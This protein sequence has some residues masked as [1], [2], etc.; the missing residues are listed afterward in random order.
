MVGTIPFAFTRGCIDANGSYVK[1][2]TSIYTEDMFECQGLTIEPD[3]KAS[4]TYQVFYYAADEMFIGATEEMNANDPAYVKGDTFPLAKYCRVLIT[5]DNG[6]D[7][8]FSVKFY[9][10][11]SYAN[12]YTITVNK[13]QVLDI[14]KVFANEA[15]VASLLGE[16]HLTPMAGEYTPSST[17]VYW[18]DRVDVTS[19][20]HIVLK[21]NNKTLENV[22]TVGST[23]FTFPTIYA[24]GDTGMTTL[25]EYEV[26]SSVG[27]C[28]YVLFD[29]SAYKSVILYSDVHS[30]DILQMVVL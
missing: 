2:N 14:S 4:G 29:V 15:N 27:G 24:Y 30:V 6:G 1:S 22:V 9:N 18:Y 26:L 11:T 8:D 16:G 13:K 7:G 23:K 12:D 28:T 3:F 17:G 19:A 21:V 10:V 5:P 20:R 25:A